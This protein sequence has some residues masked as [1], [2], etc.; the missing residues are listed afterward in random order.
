MIVRKSVT[1][2]GLLILAFSTLIFFGINL[3][4]RGISSGWL[5]II[6]GI[7]FIAVTYVKGVN[8]RSPR[9]IIDDEGIFATEWQGKKIL[10]SDIK[11]SNVRRYPRVGRIITFEL[12][13]EAKYIEEGADNTN[14]SYRV[15]RT[16]GFTAFSIYAEGLDV[17]PTIIHKEILIRIHNAQRVESL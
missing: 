4:V 7:V 5:M 12:Y 10:W 1:H 14:L 6:T 17:S 15:N 2:N 13:D 11:S 9:V 8:D 16:F 3:L